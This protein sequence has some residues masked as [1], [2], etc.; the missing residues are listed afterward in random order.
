MK[1]ILAIAVLLVAFSASASAQTL[2]G[3]LLKGAATEIIDNVTDGKL[4]EVMLVGSWS[5]SEPAIELNSSES[6]ALADIASS[7]LATSL[8]TKLTKAY[9]YVGIKP[10]SYSFTF[11]NDNTF[12]SVIGKRNFAG[13]Y[14]YD[15]ETHAVELKF[16]SKLI[17]LGTMKGFAYIDGQ[18]LKLVFDC[19]RLVNFVTQLGAKST[20]L[21]GVTSLVKGYESVMLGFAFSK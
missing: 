2:V 4:S 5:Y 14:T 12:T 11:N 17:N 18:N 6:K 19:S 3:K 20:L 15:A 13:T 10:G 8:S 16:D 21:S 9:E 1:K 7:A